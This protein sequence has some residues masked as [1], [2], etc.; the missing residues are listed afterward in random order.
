MVLLLSNIMVADAQVTTN[1][2][3]TIAAQACD[4]RI[5]INTNEAPLVTLTNEQIIVLF[6]STVPTNA[7]GPGFAAKVTVDA[8]TAKVVQII[9]GPD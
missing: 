6:A 1:E 7:R 4:G 3:I 2:A 5:E 8:K 9:A